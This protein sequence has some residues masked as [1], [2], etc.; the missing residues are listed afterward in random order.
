MRTRK[1][2][3]SD[4]YT[5]PDPRPY[6]RTLAQWDYQIP[7]NARPAVK[8]VLDACELRRPL[9]PPSGGHAGDGQVAPVVLDLCCSYAPNA[10]LLRHSLA[11]DDI[12]GHYLSADLDSLSPSELLTRDRDFYAEHLVDAELR[13]VG[14][15]ASAPAIDYARA[16]GLIDDGWAE[17]LEQREP[18]DDLASGLRDVKLI[19]CTGGVG[20]IGHQTFDRVLRCIERPYD[21]WIVLF[22]LRAFNTEKIAAALQEY[23]LVTE[24]VPAVSVRQRRFATQHEAAAAIHDIRLQGLDPAGKEDTGWLYAD[25]HIARPAT[26]AT[27]KGIPELLSGLHTAT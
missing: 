27:A 1:A 26:A 7:D 17:N 23:D 11:F 6:Y 3:F 19:V 21:V 20:Y 9:E 8:R 24:H 4:I 16:A 25:L 18:S 2:D 14:L 15:D 13:I 5:A 22:V 10:A 12:R